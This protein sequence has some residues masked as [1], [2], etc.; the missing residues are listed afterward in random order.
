MLFSKL[1]CLFTD[2]LFPKPNTGNTL[3]SKPS[4]IKTVDWMP[5]NDVLGHAKTRLFLSHLGHNS[6]Y[7]AAYH[8][9]PIV[10][11][12]MWGDHLDNARQ[13]A[14]AGMGLWLDIHR[15]TEDELRMTI[16]RVLTEERY[17]QCVFLCLHTL[18]PS[19]LR[20][21]FHIKLLNQI[22]NRKPCKQFKLSPD[23]ISN[24]H[25]SV[26]FSGKFHS[27]FLQGSAIT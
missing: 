22:K 13:I 3:N 12:P 9:V 2:K 4:N 11:F 25:A 23:Y 5:Q 1:K 20:V 14:R 8:G 21:Q 6:M 26:F 7:E 18:P 24:K 19:L 27:S 16:S 15:I 10:G 17:V